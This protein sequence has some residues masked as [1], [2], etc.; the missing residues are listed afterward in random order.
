MNTE[1]KYT[2]KANGDGTF[3]LHRNGVGLFCPKTCYP[4]P[5]QNRLAT[6]VEIQ[7]TKFNCATNCPFAEI[8]KVAPAP[9]SQKEGTFE[10]HIKCEGRELVYKLDEIV[11]SPKLSAIKN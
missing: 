6:Q 11:E 3:T 10:Y 4:L 2:A 7:I 1:N 9:G 5:V 8:A